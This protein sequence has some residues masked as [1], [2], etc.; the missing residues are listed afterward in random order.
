[1]TV[2]PSDGPWSEAAARW[3]GEHAGPAGLRALIDGG[4]HAERAAWARCDEFGLAELLAEERDPVQRAHAVAQ[5]AVEAGRNLYAGPLVEAHAGAWL[6]GDDTA[7]AASALSVLDGAGSTGLRVPHAG[8]AGRC[9]A[10]LRV[11][12]GYEWWS[13]PAVVTGATLRRNADGSSLVEMP[14]AAIET[15]DGIV[16][17]AVEAGSAGE[18]CAVVWMTTAARLLGVAQRA[19]VLSREYLVTRTQ[20]GRP[21]ASFQVLQHQAVDRH[22]EIASAQ[23]LLDRVLEHWADAGVR[24]GAVHAL[25]AHA[26]RTAVA[27]AKTCVQHFGA[28]GFSH[29]GDAGLYLRHAIALATR[30]GDERAHRQ[31]FAGARLAFMD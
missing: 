3:F 9:G 18:W 25:K 1:M 23:A 28:M 31:A 21:L 8:A 26:A 29:E 19:A 22:G 27:S 5:V 4:V 15:G 30:H 2:R 11:G 14:R 16:R 6:A 12:S 10:L 20:F 17:R 13:W 24:H 7:G